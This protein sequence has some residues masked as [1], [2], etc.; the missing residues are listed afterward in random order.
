MRLTNQQR[1]DSINFFNEPS[2][3]SIKYEYFIVSKALRDELKIN[4]SARGP[5]NNKYSNFGYF[6]SIDNIIVK[7]QAKLIRQN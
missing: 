5:R 4:I 6:F 3:T 1:I 2:F 7:R